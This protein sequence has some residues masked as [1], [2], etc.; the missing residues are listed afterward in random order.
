[1]APDRHSPQSEVDQMTSGSQSAQD[2]DASR[3]EESAPTP[4][5]NPPH[6]SENDSQ[7]T[8]AELRRVK[9]LEST[10]LDKEKL[11][12]ALTERLSQVADQLDFS[13]RTAKE[14][15]N[16]EIVRFKATEEKLLKQLGVEL[17]E[18][19]QLV[20]NLKESLEEVTGQL[21]QSQKTIDASAQEEDHRIKAMEEELLRELGEELQEKEQLVVS[22][23]SR[24]EEVTEQLEQSQRAN[25]ELT[26]AENLRVEQLESELQEKEQL[27]VIL[28]ER[29]EQVAEQLDRRHRTGADRGM[30][31]SSGIPQDVID[32]QQKLS[33]DLRTVLEQFQG[34]QKE[35]SLTRIEMQIAELK[36]LVES[37]FSN[38]P[39]APESPS[40]VDYLASPSIPALEP[41]TQEV[42]LSQPTETESQEEASAGAGI[43]EET[44]SGWEAMKEQLLSGKD[45]DVSA[46][47]IQKIPTPPPSAPPQPPP[48]RNFDSEA[49]ATEGRTIGSYKP[50]LPEAPA[51]VDFTQASQNQLIEAICERD[52]YISLLIKRVREAEM[53][54][55]PVDWDLLSNIP[56]ELVDRVK[57]LHNDLEHNL[58]MA[59]VEISIERARLSRT[60][61]MLQNREEQIRKKEKQLG[62]NQERS[63]ESVVEETELDDDRKK[64]WL[65]FLN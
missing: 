36:Q 56:E 9:E 15:A 24:L 17:Q 31:I 37:G 65:G 32:D 62:L 55:I 40:L 60:E 34:M 7:S 44:V 28:T 43:E 52:Q 13:Q 19:E 33:Q 5:A 30:T 6:Q 41:D 12:T 42:P 64:S 23:K 4:S 1:M 14:T 49:V 54:I 57:A 50:D 45:V 26:A 35:D 11:V 27:V 3:Q 38:N 48:T 51:E 10:L 21:E 58:G 46:N 25:E 22:L 47:L 39:A 29:L 18:K 59:E 8:S 20:E 53:A 2:A 61:S 63:E 16:A